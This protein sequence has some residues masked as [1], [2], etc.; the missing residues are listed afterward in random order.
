MRPKK[1]QLVKSLGP[2][3]KDHLSIL[4]IRSPDHA[5]Q[6][7]WTCL[8]STFPMWIDHKYL[9]WN[10]RH[11]K[12]LMESTDLEAIKDEYILLAL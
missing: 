2:D 5:A 9:E 6:M 7:R 11:D 12:V 4:V 1:Y 10:T 8:M 3:G